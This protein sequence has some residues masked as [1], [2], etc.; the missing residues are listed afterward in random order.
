MTVTSV[1]RTLRRIPP[2]II[3][4]MA[5]REIIALEPEACICG[6][7]LR[8]ALGEAT[9]RPAE[10][11]S[12][13]ETSDGDSVQACLDRFAGSYLEWNDVFEGICRDRWA[14]ETAFTVR[15]AECCR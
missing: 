8:A 11:V 12:H 5:T 15:V 6:W 1:L 13:N 3:R 9:G 14:V 7:A 4:D 10:D 2:W